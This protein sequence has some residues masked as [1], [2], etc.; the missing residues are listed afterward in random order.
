MLLSLDVASSTSLNNMLHFWTTLPWKISPTS[1][2][3]FPFQLKT[4]LPYPITIYSSLHSN[5]VQRPRA[6]TSFLS[7]A[8]MYFRA[9]RKG[10]GPPTP[11]PRLPCT[12]PPLW[13]QE[14]G[15]F[16][17]PILMEKA[18]AK[19]ALITSSFCFQ[20][21]SCPFSSGLMFALALH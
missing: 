10:P 16:W 13:P 20:Q 3:N 19:K 15:T 17:R 11:R 9:C 21:F 8:T 7:F 4:I 14:P 5:R 1:D 6:S 12:R 18:E 2:L